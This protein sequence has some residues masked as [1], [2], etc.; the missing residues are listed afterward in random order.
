MFLPSTCLLS[1]S[2][3][4]LN[5]PATTH[6][7]Q[8]KDNANNC[9]CFRTNGSTHYFANHIFRDFRNIGGNSGDVP[10]VITDAQQTA[11]A[12]ATSK[13]FL[14]DAWQDIWV[15]QSW[16]NSQVMADNSASVLMINS[17][18]NVYIGTD[19]TQNFCHGFR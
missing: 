7:Q 13:Y 1:F 8:Q 4:V 18:N 17:P 12:P 16:N 11:S 5:L 2:F 14:S 10:P 6:A 3:F 15:S 9:Q 19:S